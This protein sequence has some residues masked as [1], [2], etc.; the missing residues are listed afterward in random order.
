MKISVTLTANAGVAIG[1]DGHRLWVDAL[2]DQKVEGFSTVCPEIQKQMMQSNAFSNPDCICYTHCHPD[3]FS[4]ELTEEAKKLWP[5]AK[6]LLPEP[7]YAEQT[8]VQGQVFT[9]SH[10]DLELRFLRLPHEG[11][12]YAGCIHYGLVLSLQGKQVLIPGDCQVAADALAQALVETQ[13]DLAL[14][15]FP[16]LTL[17]KGQA[18]VQEVLRP[19]HT[20]LYHLPF[21]GDD[22]NGFR[23]VAQ[24][25]AIKAEAGDVQL[26][27]NP[28]QS[29]HLEL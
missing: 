19:K 7:V 13:I 20:L 23:K 27:W 16:W 5:E 2:H 12:Q 24:K 21:A 18:F 28:L 4:A 6:L 9:H 11:E 1:L 10:G 25:A 29:I 17:K 15:N 14:L 3:H 26:L 8:L 22:V